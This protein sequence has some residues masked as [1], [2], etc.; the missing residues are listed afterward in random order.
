MS[1]GDPKYLTFIHRFNPKL[2]CIVRIRDQRPANSELSLGMSFEW[3]GR[4]RPKHMREYRQ[5]I[6]GVIQALA[7][8]WNTSILYALGTAPNRTE[9]WRVVAG[10]PPQLIDK[11]NVGIS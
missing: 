6:L 3:V 10:E 8:R 11:L 1:E 4:P 7:D 5:W 9:F 2:Q